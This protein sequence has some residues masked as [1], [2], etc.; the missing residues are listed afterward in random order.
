MLDLL[1]VFINGI[2]A[3]L[4]LPLA[5]LS[6]IGG[7]K[8]PQNTVFTKYYEA[9]PYLMLAGNVFLITLAGIA[10]IKLAL[11]FGVID[12]ALADRLD[13]WVSI[14]FFIMLLVFLGLFVSA[15]LK[16]RRS[17]GTA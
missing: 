4:I 12:A 6:L 16:V 1:Q 9:Q 10:L 13:G 8:P 11:H 15:V 17:A 14:P 7:S 5:V 3:F 2:V